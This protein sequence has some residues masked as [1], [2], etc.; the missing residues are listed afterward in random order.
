R[1]IGA[2]SAGW[3]L[4]SSTR[5]SDMRMTSIL[6]AVLNQT[7]PT[8]SPSDFRTFQ[9]LIHHRYPGGIDPER[10]QNRAGRG[11]ESAVGNYD[12]VVGQDWDIFLLAAHHLSNVDLDLLPL[13]RGRVLAKDHAAAGSRPERQAL[14]QRDC[15]SQRCPLF[16]RERSR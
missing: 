12:D 13:S 6:T 15:L 16:Q 1:P 7:G 14:R 10:I 2:S 5:S 3:S 11:L 9:P 4:S 8:R